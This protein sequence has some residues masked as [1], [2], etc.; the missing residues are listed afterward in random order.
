[1][2]ERREHATAASTRGVDASPILVWNGLVTRMWRIG[3]ERRG[4]KLAGT[5]TVH[6]EDKGPT[7]EA[8]ERIHGRPV[9][10]ADSRLATPD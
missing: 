6:S 2:S 7:P 4:M 10:K 9:R 8:H 1:M 3:A 5:T